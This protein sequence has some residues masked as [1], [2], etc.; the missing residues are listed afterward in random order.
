MSIRAESFDY[1]RH[2]K[3]ANQEREIELS[4][5]LSLISKG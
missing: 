4:L 5:Q 2:F 3:H 1:A